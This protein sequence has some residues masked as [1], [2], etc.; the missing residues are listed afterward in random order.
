MQVTEFSEQF[1]SA[2]NN[3]NKS[4]DCS[5]KTSQTIGSKI[6]KAVLN[7]NNIVAVMLA[8]CAL[9]TAWATWV[10]D[11]HGSDQDANYAKADRLNTEANAS[12]NLSAQTYIAAFNVWTRVYETNAEIKTLEQTGDTQTATA[13]R[14]NLNSFIETN[15]PDYE[16][17]KAAIYKALDAGGNATPFDEYDQTSFFAESEAI[18]NEATQVREAGD[19]NNLASDSFGLVSLLYSLCLFLF[20]MVG[21]Y[22]QLTQRRIVFGIGAVVFVIAT[23]YMFTLPMPTTF[24]FTN[25]FKLVQ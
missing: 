13:K 5:K 21:F 14:Q 22:K 12:Y 23:V 16:G 19:W 18:A 9:T 24:D 1:K 8:L 10:S 11:L 25:Y 7:F 17:F 6:K 4:A 3:P 15:C 20:G 2:N